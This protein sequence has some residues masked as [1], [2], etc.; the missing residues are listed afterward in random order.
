MAKESPKSYLDLYVKFK[1]ESEG[2]PWT[3]SMELFQLCQ[4]LSGY[5][6]SQLA[7]PVI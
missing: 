2:K 4:E 1:T 7:Q 3:C 5:S 6:G